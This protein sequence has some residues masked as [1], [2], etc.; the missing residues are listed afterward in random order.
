MKSLLNLQDFHA[1]I[2]EEE[3]LKAVERNVSG[4]RPRELFEDFLEE[5]EEVYIKNRSLLRDAKFDITLEM[6]YADFL[7]ASETTADEKLA[8]IPHEH[9]SISSSPLCLSLCNGF[10]VALFQVTTLEHAC[11]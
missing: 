3:A 11:R 7:A 8:E 10:G 6:P 1:L 4:A 2:E 5:I 9:R